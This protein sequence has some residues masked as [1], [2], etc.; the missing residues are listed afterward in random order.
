ML[1]Q[2]SNVD[3]YP[4]IHSYVHR[5]IPYYL[6]IIIHGQCLPDL[7]L[8]T[9]QTLTTRL[10]GLPALEKKGWGGEGVVICGVVVVWSVGQ[11][12]MKTEGSE[13]TC[14]R[15]SISVLFFFFSLGGTGRV[16]L[17]IGGR[18][19]TTMTNTHT[20][21]RSRTNQQLAHS[22]S[23]GRR[24]ATVRGV[25]GLCTRPPDCRSVR[26][27]TETDYIRDDVSENVTFSPYVTTNDGN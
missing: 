8:Q 19:L 2:L 18:W 23:K 20:Q 16:Q 27:F 7:K 15:R 9:V 12:L 14:V 24:H 21:N 10:K 5:S 3:D 13:S 22:G 6:C 1:D 11:R 17:W 26:R 25:H 4:H